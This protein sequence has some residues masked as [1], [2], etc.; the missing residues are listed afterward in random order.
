[1]VQAIEASLKRLK[2]EY[3]DLAWLHIWDQLTPAEEVMRA[4]DDKGRRGKV[5]YTGVS[6]AP[7]WWVAQANRLAAL[8]GWSPSIGLQI[9]YSLIERS[10]ERELIP[11]ARAL[12]P[13]LVAARGRRTHRQVRRRPVHGRRTLLE[14]HDAPVP[15]GRT[16]ARAHRCSPS[17]SQCGKRPVA[18][19]GGA[20]MDPDKGDSRDPYH[21]RSQTLTTGDNLASL[22]LTLAHGQVT[23]STKGARSSLAS[24]T[25]STG[26]RW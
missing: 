16:P 18:C 7:A 9:E 26:V 19:P 13:G 8:R 21:R 2:T 22:S 15:S 24:R 4:F 17:R 1:M 14:R 23:G 20:C 6:D 10:V 11:M 5:L 12:N 25:T 3:I